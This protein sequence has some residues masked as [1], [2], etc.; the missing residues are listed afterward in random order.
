MTTPDIAARRVLGACAALVV[1]SLALTAC[2]GD[3][4]ATDNGKGG[5]NSPKAST[6]QILISA[7]DG[8]FPLIVA[9]QR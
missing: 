4:N 8:R 5:K 3:A 6:A 1:G 9:N 7:K 2:G